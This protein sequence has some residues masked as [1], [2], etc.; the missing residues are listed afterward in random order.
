[1]MK[2]N[3]EGDIE[4]NQRIMQVQNATIKDYSE[5]INNLETKVDKIMVGFY[6][7]EPSLVSPRA[8]HNDDDNNGKAK[9]A[10]N[11]GD[12][13]PPPPP[14]TCWLPIAGRQLRVGFPMIRSTP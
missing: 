12:R 11:G 8:G 4:M 1:M 13:A 14:P 3:T 6:G 2:R 9:N 10:N 5:K 7:A